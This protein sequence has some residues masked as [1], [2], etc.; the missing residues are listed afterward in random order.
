MFPVSHTETHP[1]TFNTG[2]VLMKNG[3]PPQRVVYGYEEAAEGQRHHEPGLLVSR[4]LNIIHEAE[5]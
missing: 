4:R 3:S 5:L 2:G 1:S